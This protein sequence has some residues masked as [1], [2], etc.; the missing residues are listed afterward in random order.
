MVRTRALIRQLVFWR[1]FFKQCH[2]I[3]IS[4]N[5]LI[6]LMEI[7]WITHYYF[8][9]SLLFNCHVGSDALKEYLGYQVEL[10]EV[11][12]YL[13]ESLVSLWK[14]WAAEITVTHQ[15]ALSKWGPETMARK[16]DLCTQEEAKLQKFCLCRNV[17]FQIV[18]FGMNF[19]KHK[20]NM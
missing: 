16:A 12:Y 9:F 15:K 4:V 3:N 19:Q 14:I 6:C 13:V 5:F 20:L 17:S 10:Y 8:L 18:G 1:P 2:H 7:A 11:S